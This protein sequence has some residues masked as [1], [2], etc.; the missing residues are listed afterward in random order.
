[1]DT[2]RMNHNM[3]IVCDLR[4]LYRQF[5]EHH[6][7]ERKRERGDVINFVGIHSRYLVDFSRDI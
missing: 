5:I 6:D 4:N 3:Y 1:M 7:R 2:A